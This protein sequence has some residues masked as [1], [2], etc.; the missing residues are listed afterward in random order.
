MAKQ[1][2]TASCIVDAPKLQGDISRLLGSQR[3][4]LRA[5]RPLDPDTI[6]LEALL[7]HCYGEKGPIRVGVSEIAITATGIMAGRG[8]PIELESKAMSGLIRRLG[9][10][11]KLDSKGFAI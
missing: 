6:A 3:E 4:E 5:S 9:L 8:E 7:V 2:P 10:I 11:P 1:F